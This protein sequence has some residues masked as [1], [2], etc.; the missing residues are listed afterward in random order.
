[1]KNTNKMILLSV[2]LSF[3]LIIHYI[4]NMMPSINMIA[5]GAKLGL[6]NIINL[7]LLYIFGFNEAFTVL[8]TRIFLASTFYG[9]MST[10]LYSISG[11]ICSIIAMTI[12]KKI[13]FKSVSVVGI[14]VVGSFFFNIGQLLTASFMISN[15]KIFYY[16]PY[17]SIISIATGM[18]VGITS[19][20]LINHL[21]KIIRKI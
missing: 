15:G 8:F 12:M 14:S 2:M 13:N 3:S 5:P 7:S 10:F 16:L 6:S 18:F 4:E 21:S 20:Y 19:N 11:G 1:M 17:M 9:G